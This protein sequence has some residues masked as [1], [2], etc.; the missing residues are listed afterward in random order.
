MYLVINDCRETEVVE[1]L[2]AVAPHV[3][4]AVFPL[5]LIIETIHLRGVWGVAESGGRDQDRTTRIVPFSFLNSAVSFPY[6]NP[7]SV[8]CLA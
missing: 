8:T 3:D 1:Y 5:A 4:G 2:G 6:P 7:V